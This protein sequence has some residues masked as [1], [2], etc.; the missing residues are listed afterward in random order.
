MRL[1]FSHITTYLTCPKQYF[2]RYVEKVPE[3]LSWRASFGTSLHNA[4]YRFTQ[5]THGANLWTSL[6]SAKTDQQL[7]IFAPPR[8]QPP[9]L[10]RLKELLDLHWV[11]AAYPDRPSMYAA[12]HEAL[13]LLEAWHA[14]HASE[15]VSTVA[16]ELPFLFPLSTD[17]FLRGRIDRIDQHGDTLT[18]VDYKSG[19][20]RTQ[21]SVDQ[22][23]QLAFYALILQEHFTLDKVTVGLYFL[24]DQT[25]VHTTK[26]REQGQELQENVL[27]V[28]KQLQEAVYDSTPSIASCTTCPFKNF[29]PQSLCASP[30][31]E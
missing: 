7:G 6:E 25:F 2:Y 13:S 24:R 28:G 11:D 4:L 19:Y 16:V 10:E 21:E 30:S 14:T 5:E 27:K 29:C 22:D 23:L 31:E 9:S 12:K 20:V 1:S 15:I 8:P 3:P 18:V 17:L 26:T